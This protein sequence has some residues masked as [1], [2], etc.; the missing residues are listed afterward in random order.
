MDPVTKRC[1]VLLEE[2][3]RCKSA[4]WSSRDMLELIRMRLEQ[5]MEGAGTPSDGP[6]TSTAASTSMGEQHVVLLEVAVALSR[7]ACGGQS[8]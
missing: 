7:A 5:N 1:R 6:S 4:T 8:K 3:L 2:Y